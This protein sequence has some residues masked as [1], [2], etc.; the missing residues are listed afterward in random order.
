M[1]KFGIIMYEQ[2][3]TAHWS[4]E[5]ACV[6]PKDQMF[7]QLA[8][9]SECNRR[10]SAQ[11][12]V[13]V[14]GARGWENN[15]TNI[16]KMMTTENNNESESDVRMGRSQVSALSPPREL[17]SILCRRSH[18]TYNQYL[19]C[20]WSGLIWDWEK[21]WLSGQILWNIY[22]RHLLRVLSST[23]LY[24]ALKHSSKSF[25]FSEVVERKWLCPPG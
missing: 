13:T 11:D 14:T 1:F 17:H 5:S 4:I 19:A 9:F 12:I 2:L 25:L 15:N 22:S 18:Q 23:R 6:W 7:P 20:W 3:W 8:S 16:L 10:S 24:Q 21:Y